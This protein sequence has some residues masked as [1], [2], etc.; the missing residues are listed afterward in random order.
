MFSGVCVLSGVCVPSGV[1]VSC[2]MC[3]LFWCQNDGSTTPGDG[4]SPTTYLTG[5]PR[6]RI[7]ASTSTTELHR[8]SEDFVRG[9]PQAERLVEWIFDRSQDAERTEEV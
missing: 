1:C 8:F 5:G 7:I 4:A 2:G 6:K 9:A 3:V